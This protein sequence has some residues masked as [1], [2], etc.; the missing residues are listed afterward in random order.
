MMMMMMMMMVVMV[1]V[2]VVVHLW[3]MKEIEEEQSRSWPSD[4]GYPSPYPLPMPTACKH[5][6]I[7]S[8]CVTS[9]VSPATVWSRLP[10]LS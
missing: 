2:L 10:R 7:S 4:R 6:S 8:A 1:V 9:R 5:P 3:A